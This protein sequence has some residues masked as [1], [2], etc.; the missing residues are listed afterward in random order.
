MTTDTAVLVSSEILESK[1]NLCDLK[2]TENPEI[3]TDANV[4]PFLDFKFDVDKLADANNEIYTKIE[5]LA[6]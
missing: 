3:Q 2:F 4:K 1:S 6:L 5:N